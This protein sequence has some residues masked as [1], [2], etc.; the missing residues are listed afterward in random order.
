[1]IARWSYGLLRETSKVLLDG[2]VDPAT[3]A[4]VREAVERDEDNAVAD[5]HLWRIGP[6]DFS[7]IVSVVTHHPRPPAHYEALISEVLPLSHVTVQV[8]RCP[9]SDG[10]TA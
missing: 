9:T 1:M 2:A 6:S 4:L 3:V 8:N 5:I 7:A 10:S